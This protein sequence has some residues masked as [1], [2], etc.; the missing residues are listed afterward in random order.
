MLSHELYNCGHLYE[1]AAAHHGATGRRD[2]L[3]VALKSARLLNGVFGPDGRHD[4]PGHQIVEMG[5]ASLYRITGDASLLR[6]ARFFLEGRGHHEGRR[7]YAHDDNPGYSQDH[8]PV[9][10]QRVAVGH[11]VRAVYLYTGMADVAA[12]MGE[13]AYRVALESIWRDLVDT[14]IYLT[15]GLGARRNGEA[16]GDAYELPNETAYAE[17]CAAIGSVAWCHRMFLASGDARYIDVL[18]QTLYN[19]LLSGVSLDGRSFFY[20]N[21]LASDGMTPFNYGSSTRQPWFECSCCPTNLCRFLPSLPGYLYA[22][23]PGELWVNLFAAGCAVV[24]LAGV[25]CTIHQRTRYPWDGEVRLTLDPVSPVSACLRV[26]VPGW[27]L[28]TV[29]GGRLYRYESPAVQSPTLAVNGASIPFRP[30][31]GYA[32]IDRVWRRGDTVDLRLPM[33][34][35]KVLSDERVAANRGRAA[36]QRGP[37]V[38]CVEGLD[39]VSGMGGLR[40]GDVSVLA[41]RW[42]PE[43]LGG[44]VTVQG[45]GFRAVPYYTWANRGAGP[46]LTWLPNRQPSVG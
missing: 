23:A 40:L 15:G 1:A 28:D 4:V 24:E 22:A 46:M 7:P 43:L 20:P 45:S 27:A 12:L 5:L 11:A 10:E 35:R 2:L 31:N 42:E 17:T 29:L 3:E 14:R 37:L 18:E 39:T 34:V 6:L 33:P 25:S 16:F 41:T 19:G 21:P 32:V 44:V 38:Y 8:V 30:E 36:I 13:P 26:R 9:R